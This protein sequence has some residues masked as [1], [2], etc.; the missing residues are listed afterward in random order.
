[1]KTLHYRGSSRCIRAIRED[2]QSLSITAVL[3]GVSGRTV[4]L[5]RISHE[6]QDVYLKHK[7]RKK[8][9]YFFFAKIF[10]RVTLK[11]IK[12]KVVKKCEINSFDPRWFG[13]S[14]NSKCGF[15]VQSLSVPGVSM[16]GC[17]FRANARTLCDA[18]V[19][20]GLARPRSAVGLARTQGRSVMPRF[21]RVSHDQNTN[22]GKK[23]FYFSSMGG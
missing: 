3:Q 5:S 9:F 6:S 17:G 2:R 16:I 7:F 4:N 15:G 11:K 14:E 13:A 20:Q 21:L 10:F 1:M 19:P 22:L 23:T 12:K 18:A 8:T